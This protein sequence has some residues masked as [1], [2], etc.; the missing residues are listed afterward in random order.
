MVTYA[1]PCTKGFHFICKNVILFYVK[2][3]IF[4]IFQGNYI[5]YFANSNTFGLAMNFSFVK[6]ISKT[7][8]KGN[9]NKNVNIK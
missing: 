2:S 8:V 9:V 6:I 4:I 1:P 7:V 5:Y 3:F